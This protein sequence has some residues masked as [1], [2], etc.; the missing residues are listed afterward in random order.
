[1]EVQVAERRREAIRITS[2]PAWCRRQ[3]E[4]AN[5][6]RTAVACGRNPSKSHRAAESCTVPSAIHCAATAVGHG[7]PRARASS[8]STGWRPRIACE[9]NAQPPSKRVSAGWITA[10]VLPVPLAAR[11][12]LPRD[13]GA[14]A[15]VRQEPATPSTRLGE[16]GPP[17]LVPVSRLVDRAGE[18]AE[19]RTPPFKSNSRVRPSIGRP[20]ESV[21]SCGRRSTC[22]ARDSRRPA[23]PHRASRRHQAQPGDVL[24]AA[25]RETA[26]EEAVSPEHRFVAAA[27][28]E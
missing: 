20:R 1:M 3:S 21:S 9:P 24:L 18:T 22:R 7:A 8:H 13:A 25:R 4:S 16:A 23:N 26:A 15:S 17:Q 14:P 6:N 2:L 11:G 12:S 28:A 27:R 5:G 19:R 10:A